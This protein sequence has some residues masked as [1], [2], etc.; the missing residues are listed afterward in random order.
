MSTRSYI[1]TGPLNKFRGFYIHSDGY[2]DAKVP[3]IVEWL[4]T[5][6]FSQWVKV[7]KKTR[8]AGG[9]SFNAHLD[10]NS[11]VDSPYSDGPSEHIGPED[12]LD[13]EYTYVVTRDKIDVYNYG[14]KIGS[15]NWNMNPNRKIIEYLFKNQIPERILNDNLSYIS[16]WIIYQESDL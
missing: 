14:D 10:Q 16:S 11:L 1:G 8:G 6:G 2:P 13:Q 12:A 9:S 5:Y 3:T 4:R 7:V 15:V